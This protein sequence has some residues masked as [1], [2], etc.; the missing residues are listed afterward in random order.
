ML[1]LQLFVGALMFYLCYL[2]LFPY[3]GVQHIL[4]CV[5]CFV[6]LPLVC[7]VCFF[8]FPLRNSLTF[9]YIPQTDRDLDVC[10][11]LCVPKLEVRQM[12]GSYWFGRLYCRPLL[13]NMWFNINCYK[14]DNIHNTPVRKHSSD[15]KMGHWNSNTN[16]LHSNKWYFISIYIITKMSHD[17][18]LIVFRLC[19]V[20]L[21]VSNT[22][23][24]VFFVLF[25][26]VLCLVSGGVQH[27]LCCVFCFVCLRPVS[28][29]P[30][31][32]GFSALSILDCPF[33]FL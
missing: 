23:C 13:F 31:V 17:G 27:F 18:I 12:F 14:A 5:F 16:D 10:Q 9:I 8:L 33:C 7:P 3:S 20:C 30:N 21:V 6:C 1:I 28:C 25:V 29:A 32:A 2:Y 15:R 11:Y 24:V 19:M 26:F 4:C 22:F